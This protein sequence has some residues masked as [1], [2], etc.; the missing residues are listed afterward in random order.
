MSQ[1]QSVGEKI[2]FTEKEE[3]FFNFILQK[4]WSVK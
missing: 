1:F 2:E 4:S 3:P